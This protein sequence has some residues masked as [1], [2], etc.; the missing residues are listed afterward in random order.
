MTKTIKTWAVLAAMAAGATANGLFAA[1]YEAIDYY[2][3][4]ADIDTNTSALR[5]MMR[6]A[7]E[8]AVTEPVTVHFATGTYSNTYKISNNL[9]IF[10]NMT[11]EVDDGV[12][13]RM[14][15]AEETGMLL[16]QHYQAPSEQCPRD[17]YCAHGGYSQIV[18]VTI[19]GG[20]WDRHCANDCN[21]YGMRLV[22]GDNITI[23]DLTIKGCTGHMLNLSGSRNVTVDNVT[24]TDPVKYKGNSADFWGEYTRGDKTRYNTIEA[25]HLD[26]CTKEG[27]PNSFPLD[28]TGCANV[29]IKNCTFTNCFSGFG[30]HHVPDAGVAK[31][32]KIAV[33]GCTFDGS[34]FFAYAF[35]FG[36]LIMSGNTV[37]S[38]KGLLNSFQSTSSASGNTVSGATDNAVYVNDKSAAT[39]SGNTITGGANAAIRADGSSTLIANNNKVASAGKHAISITGGTLSASGNTITSPKENGF[40]VNGSK[41]IIS[42]NTI[43][44]AGKAGIRADAAADLTASGNTIKAAQTMAFSLAEKSKYSLSGNKIDG[45][46][47]IGIRVEGCAANGV[48][49]GNEILNSG[50]RGI[51]LIA[52]D[53]ATITGNTITATGISAAAK[54]SG[55]SDEGIFLDGT[56]GS[57][58]GV[59]VSGNKISKAGGYGVR[60][61]RASATV[62]GNAMTA[63]GKAGLRVNDKSTITATANTIDSAKTYG[64]SVD[65]SSKY[66]ITKNTVTKSKTDGIR[67]NACASGGTI[68]GNTV[69]NSGERGIYVIGSEKSTVSGNTVTTTGKQKEGIYVFEAKAAT[70]KGNVVTKTGGYGIRV[71]GKSSSKKMTA[72]IELNT[73]GSANKSYSDI[74]IGDYC[75]KCTVSGNI[76]QSANAIS[77]SKNGTSG[78]KITKAKFS[79]KLFRNTTAKDKTSKSYSFDFG[80]SKNLTKF[81]KLSWKNTGYTFQGWARAED[82]TKVV[83]KDAASVVGMAAN[84]NET[85][86][87]YAVW[88]GNS[89]KI[90]FE[91]NGGKGSAPKKISASYG[92]AVKLSANTYT[93][94]GYS[95]TGWNTKAN[96]KGTKYKDGANVKNLS[97]KNGATVKLY[98]TWKVTKYK[99]LFNANGGGGKKMS[100]MDMKGGVAK[101]LTKNVFTRTGYTFA[102]WN[103]QADGKGKTYKDKAS[104]KNLTAVDGA[105]V[106]LY[107]IWTGVP[108]TIAF[109][110][111]GGTGSMGKLAMVY[112]TAKNLTPN[113]FTRA[114]YEFQGWSRTKGGSKAFADGASVNNLTSTSGG[115]VTLHAVWKLRTYT[116]VFDAN[117]G[118]GSMAAMAANAGEAKN[119]PTCTMSRTG[120]K[121]VGWNTEADG[122]GDMYD[123]EESVEDLTEE[124]GATVT[125]YAIWEANT[126]YVAYDANGGT[127]DM[128]DTEMTY[129]E[130]TNL[131]D[132]EFERED[133]LFQGW[134]TTADGD[135][136]YADGATVLNLTSEDE[137]TVTMYAVWRLKKYTVAFDANGGT[138]EM[139]PM[140]V[141][142]GV[143]TNLAANAL[144]GP[145]YYT[146]AG[147]STT[148]DGDV[149]YADGA[150]INDLTTE[151]GETVTLYAVWTL[152]TEPVNELPAWAID[153]YW[154]SNDTYEVT[155]DIDDETLGLVVAQIDLAV[156]GQYYQATNAIAT[157]PVAVEVTAEL[158]PKLGRTTEELELIGPL[159]FLYE[160]VAFEFVDDYDPEPAFEP[161]SFTLD[162]YVY[163]DL[164]QDG[165]GHA[166][167]DQTDTTTAYSIDALPLED[168]PLE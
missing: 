67:V 122:S 82:K 37:S 93:R 140:A 102:G 1:T 39:I 48:I 21:A 144:I 36:D 31:A 87:L 97:S 149:E 71:Q 3:S 28:G 111:N 40:Y 138:G 53:K 120:Y 159:A 150:S 135:V 16:A 43:Q 38:G 148:A 15:C 128:D 132:N 63:P 33:Q 126:Y 104:V 137:A 27:E 26:F 66:T 85:V 113:K 167:S 68:S 5:T 17:K 125:L 4:S 64:I 74:R 107:A 118:T 123:D 105:T 124:N 7:G 84:V 9:P 162:I 14:D 78:T 59:T 141:D 160:G 58:T 152:S 91:K 163:C 92:T 75:S 88:K 77:E 110:A 54:K 69:L 101:N 134:S 19:K 12:T 57:T 42:G 51:N 11:V 147:W 79:V 158:L 154:C 18:N 94:D 109:D 95:F 52:T 127:G 72:K 41:A 129:D 156:D 86:N 139:E 96:G 155:L 114:G 47:T 49:A 76:T 22:H 131:D 121:F 20:V 70:I 73:A 165:V 108:Y 119:L 46:A 61:E 6:A 116:V 136:E 112:G 65:A 56:T 8:A 44:S 81:S 98:A 2:D 50:E 100:A 157:P 133:H 168:S 145:A 62:E 35:G 164:D 117:G 151:D 161:A 80:A 103:T 29:T 166:V 23:K 106:P 10:S 89:Y 60:L 146:F 32:G 55:T 30:T 99:I 24:F 142:A 45:T 153:T 90:T 143:T 25:V 130:E 83:Y 115:T 34:S 13:I